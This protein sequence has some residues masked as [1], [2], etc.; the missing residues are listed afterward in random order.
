MIFTENKEAH[1]VAVYDIKT[2]D[3]KT[4]RVL[5][6]I[7]LKPHG[8][9]L[10]TVTDIARSTTST[11]RSE[12][13]PKSRQAE[14]PALNVRRYLMDSKQ[15]SCPLCY[16]SRVKR[17][18]CGTYCTGGLENRDGTCDR[19]IYCHDKKA[20][21]AFKTQEA[22]IYDHYKMVLPVRIRE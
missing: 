5:S 6:R 17:D 13:K 20:I 16:F 18:I 10:E 22:A 21:G 12:C 2:S 3:G 11:R 4:V 9:C 14:T 8:T 15:S 7:W 1:T 19:Y